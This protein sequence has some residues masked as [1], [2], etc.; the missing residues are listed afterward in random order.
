M[1]TKRLSGIYLT[2]VALG[3]VLTHHTVAV[4]DN[5]LPQEQELIAILESDAP[6]QDKAVPC[7]QLAV[8]GTEAAVPALAQL[9]PNSDLSSW[10]RIAL[11]AIPGPA[12]DKALRDAIDQV[13]GRLLIGIINSI[14]VRRDA[15]ASGALIPHLQNDNADVAV[16]AA[17]A[18]G[19]IGSEAASNAL[20]QKLDE[21]RAPVRSAIAE[22]CVLCAE[23][24]LDA[25]NNAE[26][27]RLYD[28]VRQAD[29]PQ[30]RMLESTRGAIL[31]RG[32]DGIPLLIEQLG[33][34]DKAQFQ[35]G[36][37]TAREIPGAVVTQA[38]VA[39]LDQATPFRQ[40]MVVLALAGRTDEKV[41]PAVMK[42]AKSG[43]MEVRLV[44]M[45]AL[46]QVGDVSC[47][48][49]LLEVA[50]DANVD[51]SRMAKTALEG[52]SGDQVNADLI[53]R[54]AEAKGEM[55]QSIIEVIG[56]RRI[57]DA[58]PQLLKAVQDTDGETRTAALL[59]LGET[60]GPD[61]LSVLVKRA[62]AAAHPS[63]AEAEAALKALRTACVR[64]PDREACA[65]QLVEAMPQAPAGTQRSMVEIL[66]AMGG[67]N[68]LAAVGS[69]AKQGAPE[70]KDAASRVLGEWMSA[71]AAPV[72]LDLAKTRRNRNTAFVRLRDS[73][74]FQGS[75][76]CPST[77]PLRCAATQSIP[78]SEILNGR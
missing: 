20:V 47:V 22:G 52:M 57:K 2:L 42:I 74:E 50:T 58:V 46:Q 71:D 25:G 62:A 1:N 31:A 49:A 16:A 48:T 6:P 65:A 40:M 35:L 61:N 76:T 41:L 27:I 43:P 53:G 18:L 23:K 34:D 39:Q 54:L 28:Q 21:S 4:A 36:L 70:V 63:P 51:L 3:T 37:M 32:S 11:E 14:A 56:L 64:M 26:A 68:A 15:E 73:C 66:G 45:E 69:A 44:A 55:R 19:R 78:Q 38:L 24:Q 8:V 9:L 77:R 33:S 72:L 29:V 5:Q 75:L 59:A 13:D 10:A 60:V 17:I 12:A 30:Q 67:S 7:K